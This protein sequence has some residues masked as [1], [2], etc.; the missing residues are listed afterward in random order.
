MCNFKYVLIFLILTV[1]QARVSSDE[2]E[3]PINLG[4]NE[5]H[6]YISA[7]GFFQDEAPYLKE[8]IEYHILLG[9]QHFYLYNNDSTDNYME[10]L[11]PYM[12]KGIV[13]LFQ[14]PS[15]VKGGYWKDDQIRAYNHCIKVCS[16]ITDWLVIIDIDE[17]IVPIVE[18]DLVAFLKN[19]DNSPT[20][21]G[22]QINWQLFGTSNLKK[23]SK[24]KLLIES[25]IMKA[26]S[27]YD[28][29]DLPNNTIFKSIVRPHAVDK[30]EQHH[31]TYKEGFSAI[32]SG[33]TS[34][35]QPI[36][37]DQIQV[38]HYWTRAEDFFYDVK[39]G[40]RLRFKPKRY[41]AI[42]LNKLIELNIVEDT[43]IL[44]YVPKLKE[45]MN[46]QN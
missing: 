4:S 33:S 34:Y 13:D 39:I 38:N 8:W 21:G 44:K 27:N 22:I 3:N 28:S 29:A 9:C 17:F 16:G 19:Y 23:I 45:R 6:Y 35:F 30:F 18:P 12:K 31:G 1:T 5:F 42:M 32:P 25:L 20:V 2:I 43:T 37:I 36:N 11:E 41:Y 10:V 40:R 14:W 26:P 46:N 24:N 7:C 15:S